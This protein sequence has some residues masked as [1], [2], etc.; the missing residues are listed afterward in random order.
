VN[1]AQLNNRFALLLQDVLNGFPIVHEPP[2]MIRQQMF[3]STPWAL[4][5][6]NPL[7]IA[8][9]PKLFHGT[10][11]AFL[12]RIH[13]HHFR[14]LWARSHPTHAV[15]VSWLCAWVAVNGLVNQLLIAIRDGGA[16]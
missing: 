4:D 7:L 2:E 9:L 8:V 14:T 15:F 5:D 11:G 3:H 12:A 6:D 10:R 1:T 16:R 13:A